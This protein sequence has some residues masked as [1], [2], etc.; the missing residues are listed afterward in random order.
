MSA[1]KAE[2]A[3]V[4]NQSLTDNDDKESP[5]KKPR[6]EPSEPPPPVIT[7][8]DDNDSVEKDDPKK[9]EDGQ[10]DHDKQ[11]DNAEE[12]GSEQG[13]EEE[14]NEEEESGTENESEN[15]SDGDSD[16]SESIDDQEFSS[17]L[18]PTRD[19]V[20]HPDPQQQMQNLM[21]DMLAMRQEN[22]QLLEEHAERLRK[23]KSSE[24]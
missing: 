21:Q 19:G 4:D 2:T 7:Q 24:M 17:L 22:A 5:L 1:E 12:S 15:D 14:G 23:R 11:E 10:S 16:D 9:V 13:E 6:C 3:V 20:K 8:D 18:W